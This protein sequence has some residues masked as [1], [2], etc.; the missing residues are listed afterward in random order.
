MIKATL[1][2]QRTN[3]L[4]LYI[5]MS[6]AL[7]TYPPFYNADILKAFYRQSVLYVSFFDTVLMGMFCCSS[8]KERWYI[9]INS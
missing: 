6:I 8:D 9:K 4:A 1:H 7:C 3:R 5:R 2:R